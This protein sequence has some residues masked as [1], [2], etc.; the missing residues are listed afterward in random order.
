MPQVVK[1]GNKLGEKR[2]DWEIAKTQNAENFQHESGI[3]Y[4]VGP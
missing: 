4:K 2:S 3:P 1:F